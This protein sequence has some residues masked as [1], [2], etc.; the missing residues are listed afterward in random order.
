MKVSQLY[1]HVSTTDVALVPEKINKVEDKLHLRVKWFNVVDK[2]NIF[3]IDYD[4]VVIEEAD[5]DK[6]EELNVSSRGV[7]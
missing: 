2:E 3:F 1:K 5:L 4:E 6:W 7:F